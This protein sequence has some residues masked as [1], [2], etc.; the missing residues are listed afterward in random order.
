MVFMKV[1]LE[2]QVGGLNPNGFIETLTEVITAT[3]CL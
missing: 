1:E 2:R 3:G